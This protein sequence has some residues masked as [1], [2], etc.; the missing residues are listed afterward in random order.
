MLVLTTNFMSVGIFSQLSKKNKT[1]EV[2][3]SFSGMVF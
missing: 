1:R 3:V 2:L